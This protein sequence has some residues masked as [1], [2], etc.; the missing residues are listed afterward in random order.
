M[1]RFNLFIHL[2][3]VSRTHARF[4]GLFPVKLRLPQTLVYTTPLGI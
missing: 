3:K 1:L 2:A 4:F